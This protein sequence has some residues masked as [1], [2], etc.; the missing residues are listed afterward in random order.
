MGSGHDGRQI[1]EVFDA[2]R[3]GEAEVV[4]GKAD[5]FKR[6]SAGYLIYRRC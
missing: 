5:F 1:A 2:K 3:L 6:F 4:K